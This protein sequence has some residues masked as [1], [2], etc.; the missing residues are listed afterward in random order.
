MRRKRYKKKRGRKKVEEFH[1][2]IKIE[3]ISGKGLKQVLA[4]FKNYCSIVRKRWRRYWTL[5]IIIRK[6]KRTINRKHK[7]KYKRKI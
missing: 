4:C 6:Y 3:F 5:M 1:I 7:R 2:F